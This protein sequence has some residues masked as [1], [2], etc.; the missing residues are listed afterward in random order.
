M[1]RY[2]DGSLRNLT[3]EAG[4]GMDGLQGANAIAVREPTVHWSGTKALFSMVVGAPTAQYQTNA[5]YWQIYEVSGLAKGETAR[6]T[7]ISNQPALFNNI[8]PL[9]GTDDRV[10]FTSDRP[11]SGE[12]H[13]YPQLDEYESQPTNTG[14]WSLNPATGDLRM[15]NHAVSGAFSPSIDS[16]GRVVFTR[17]DHLQQDQ[18]ADA[19]RRGANTFGSTSFAS[20]AAGAASIGLKAEVFPEALLGS[21]SAYGAVREFQNNFF[22]PWQINED[23]TD[24]ETLNHIGR[25]EFSFGFVGR[26]FTADSALVD[27]PDTADFRANRKYIRADAGF[28]HMREDPRNPGRFYATYSREFGSLTSNQIVRFD[29]GPTV[30]PEKVQ[31]QDVTPE[32]A[33]DGSIIGGRFR[34]PLPMTSGALVASHTVTTQS[35]A[36]DIKQFLLKKLEVGAGG[37]YA[38]GASLTGGI[39]KS[40]SWWDPDTKRAFDGLLWELEPVEVV[41]RTRP[42]MRS[43]PPLE[44]PEQSIFTTEAVDPTEFTNWMRTNGLAL[45]VTRN[46]TSRD[47]ADRQQPYNLQVPGGTKTVAPGGGQIYN[48][49][50]F[51]IFQ[52]D[53]IRGYTRYPGR[54][55]IA[56]PMQGIKNPENAGGPASSVKIASDGST[57]A[58]VPARRAVTWQ[59]TDAA[60]N[61]VVR[62]R[63]WVTMQ[64]GEVRVCASCHGVNTV[65]QAGLPS[66]TNP[67][68]ALRTL[69]RYW[70]TIK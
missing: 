30:N 27:V 26:S 40:V 68:E 35:V 7:K 3:K 5:Y 17:W 54:R 51:Q 8:S 59:T 44:S 55:P 24:E 15:L 11:R 58:F 42:A 34:N 31:V 63:V 61:A 9:Y 10:L 33:L 47:R 25:H 4:F 22:S 64:P 52:A 37:L 16:Y 2:P 36:A 38:A 6:I 50:H 41:S 48:I 66:P 46:Q 14:I 1:I 29:A 19:D 65:N 23:G 18:Q 57:A 28:F 13:L 56:N 62:E 45:I 39:R 12:R 67:P 32:E 21:T 53:Q 70:K 60:G 69:L 20:E 43:A 49:A